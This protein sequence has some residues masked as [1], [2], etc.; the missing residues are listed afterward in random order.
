MRAVRR[1]EGWSRALLALG[2]LVTLVAGLVGYLNATLVN[3][4]RF[5]EL[6]NQIRQDEQVKATVGQAIADAAIDAQPDLVA[7]EPALDA[8]A[9]LVVG[10][11]LLDPV[12]TPAIR[13]FHQAL[14]EEGGS[15]AV[16]A[17]ADL[18]ATFLARRRLRTRL[19]FDVRHCD[20]PAS[21]AFRARSHSCGSTRRKCVISRVSRNGTPLAILVL[22]MMARAISVTW[23]VRALWSSTRT[24]IISGPASVVRPGRLFRRALL[25]RWSEA[26]S[27]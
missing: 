3:G 19:D 7:I 25:D 16:L 1:S 8:A 9:A 2:A 20:L 12:F 21:S 14:T 27:P 26:G 23:L 10:S 22:Q 11:P 15:N 5:A 6:V 4:D 17:L 18:G 24:M 13:S